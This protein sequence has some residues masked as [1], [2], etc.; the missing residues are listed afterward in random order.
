M[1]VP[2]TVKIKGK[3]Y[4]VTAI[5]KQAFKGAKAKLTQ[6]T[7][8]KNVRVIEQKAFYGCKKLKKITIQSK[9]LNKVGKNAIGRIYRKAVIKVPKSKVNAYKKKFTKKTGFQKTMKLTK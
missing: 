6:V 2:A 5:S 9:V 1:T 7:I 8:G 3:T 4:K